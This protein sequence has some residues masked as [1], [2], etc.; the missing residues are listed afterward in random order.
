MTTPFEQDQTELVPFIPKR[1]D[2]GAGLVELDPATPVH[3]PGATNS[4]LL[5]AVDIGEFLAMDIPPR[6]MMLAPILPTQGLVMLFSK[7]GVGKTHVALGI[8]YAVASGGRFLRWQADRPRRTLLL[9]GEMPAAAMQERLASIVA[10]SEIEPPSPDYLKIITPDLQ[11][12]GIPD[13]AGDEGRAA[14]EAHLDG[15]D[16]VIIDNLST[17]CRATRENEGDSWVPVQEWILNLR[18]RGMSALLVHHAG[19]GG[20]QRGTSRREDVLDTIINLKRPEDYTPEE[21]ARF[22]VHLEKA[23]GVIGEDAKPF[24]AKLEVRNGASFWTT[25]PCRCHARTGDR[26]DEARHDGP[27]HRRRTRHL[28]IEGQPPSEE[29]PR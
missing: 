9:D 1:G 29:G 13:V 12:E 23:R 15:V 19:K 11:E 2:G 16:L 14:V 22:E 18:R 5:R 25:R 6:E 10:G 4:P 27:G 20:S 3:Q 7:R 26:A 21:G 28:E 8:A 17:L 24:E